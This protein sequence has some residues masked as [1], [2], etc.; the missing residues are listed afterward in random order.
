MTPFIHPIMDLSIECTKC[1][2]FFNFVGKLSDK[3]V[4]YS[5]PK[6]KLTLNVYYTKEDI[7]TIELPPSEQ[8]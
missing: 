5:C 3:V 8:N 6:C 7:G 4:M 2:K 1:N